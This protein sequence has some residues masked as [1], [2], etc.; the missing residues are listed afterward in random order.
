MGL[1]FW[2]ASFV[3]TATP[4][5]GALFTIAAGLSR[6][7]RMAQ[8]A[9]AGCA[10]GAL[11]HLLLALSGA[12]AV[13]AATPVAFEVLKWAGA[14]YLLYMAWGTWHRRGMLA[15]GQGGEGR[16]ASAGR[17]IGGAVLVNLLN[18]KLTLF[19]FVFLPMFADPAAPG[20]TVR[21][22]LLGA[23]FLAVTLVVFGAYGAC[24]ASLRRYVIGK[25]V[26]MERIGQFFGLSFVALAVMLAF[27]PR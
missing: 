8:L 9:A 6:G 12:A 21:M 7:A 24:A 20:S 16:T 14:G 11:P 10:L 1:D 25:P 17:T 26:V 3:V 19:F 4:G 2:I 13:L 23:A 5:S 22:A 18:P 15:P 27:T